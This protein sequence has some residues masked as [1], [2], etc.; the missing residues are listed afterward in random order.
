MPENI[1]QVAVEMASTIY[2][3]SR[4]GDDSLGKKQESENMQGVSTTTIYYELTPRHE[5]SLKPYTVAVFP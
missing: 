3:E 1:Q 4:I 2:R 5:E